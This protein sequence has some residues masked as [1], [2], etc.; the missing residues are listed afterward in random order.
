MMSNH[1]EDEFAGV[2]PEIVA[3]FKAAYEAGVAADRARIAA[4]QYGDVPDPLTAEDEAILD[5][6][7]DALR[8]KLSNEPAAEQLPMARGA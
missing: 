5:R 6:A 8:V 1:F 2:P 7:W 4:G 3:R